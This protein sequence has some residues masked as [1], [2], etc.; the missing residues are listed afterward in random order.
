MSE[1]PV[2]PHTE[3]PLSQHLEQLDRQIA[4]TVENLVRDLH[5][6]LG[7]RI[8]EG[9]E[10]MLRRLQELQPHLPSSFVSSDKV[11]ELIESVAPKQVSSSDQLLEAIRRIDGESTQ[12]EILQAL[13]EEARRFADRSAFFLVRV[14]EVRGWGGAGWDASEEA[15]RSLRF[16]PSEDSAWNELIDGRNAVRLDAERCRTF[17]ERV[18]AEA[19]GH[20]ILVPFVLRG[21]LAG[22]LYAD[23]AAGE[24]DPDFSSLQLLT[25]SAAQALETVAVRGSGTSP[26]LR[27]SGTDAPGVPTWKPPT[28]PVAEP[29]P[30]VEEAPEPDTDETQPVAEVAPE[31]AEPEAAEAVVETT[32]PPS[33]DDTP[34]P[35]IVAPETP[36]TPDVSTEIEPGF[37]LEEDAPPQVEGFFVEPVE[38]TAAEPSTA[39]PPTEEIQPTDSL[40]AETQLVDVQAARTQIE[41]EAIE[42]DALDA[43]PVADEPEPV[44]EPMEYIEPLAATP[45]D[46]IP[47]T[48]PEVEPAG[49]AIEYIE[50]VATDDV[51]MASEEPSPVA[52]PIEYVEPTAPM[53]VDAAPTPSAPTTDDSQ[54][55]WEE[56]EEPTVVQPASPARR[57]PEAAL[58]VGQ[59]TVRLDPSQLPSP[60]AVAETPDFSAD[61][62]PTSTEAPAVEPL[63][64]RAEAPPVETTQVARPQAEVSPPSEP[65]PSTE[66]TPPPDLAPRAAAVARPAPEPPSPPV[67]APPPSGGSTEVAPPEDLQ[68]PGSAFAQPS[69]AQAA[70]AERSADE[71]AL[72]EE[73]RRLARLLVSEIKLYNE[74]VIE[75]GRMAGNIYSRLRED[76]DRSR[77]M[78]TERID[79]RV[80]EDY[81]QQELVQRLAGG[82]PKLLGM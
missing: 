82:E 21:Q 36:T 23:R 52:E 13:I 73:A 72:H 53:E 16:T 59:Q 62:V 3:Q 8:R 28:A 5:Q 22:T 29:P 9:S 57:E 12:A 81:F 77:Q 35:E 78:Y 70:A 33:V 61:P 66:V 7:E 19:A 64:P 58:D 56:D 10:E 24:P 75:E 15:L 43:Q 11:S 76:I 54:D 65:A 38:P 51:E 63:A 31:A 30:A 71:E 50:P 20:G 46:E 26:A 14:G 79:P 25:H 34:S 39:E 42:I 67:S 44:A 4:Q 45:E 55:I 40:S 2:E 6:E 17:A 74:E 60:G 47:A 18:D 27:D 49:E 37:S 69:Q 41:A 32:S 80:E 68:G 48:E 1:S